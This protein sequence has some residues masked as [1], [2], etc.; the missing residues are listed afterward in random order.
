MLFRSIASAVQ[1]IQPAA[2]IDLAGLRS[3]IRAARA[4]G[5][6]LAFVIYPRHA[7]SLE[8]EFACGDPRTRWSHIAAIAQ[9]VAE[10]APDSSA[11]LWVFDGYDAP[12]GERVA[13]REPV[14]WQDPEHFNFELGAR[15]LAAIYASE[16]GRE[17]GFG[18][19]VFPGNI[20]AIYTQLLAQRERFLVS[21]DWFYGD[22][23]ALAAPA[24]ALR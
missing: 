21:A 23:R 7:L 3:V 17:Q 16:Y 19:K 15:M 24:P 2:N 14:Y 4:H 10:E 6:E 22:L 5:A 11:S 8:L 13:G 18:A 1:P 20:D 9:A 12:R